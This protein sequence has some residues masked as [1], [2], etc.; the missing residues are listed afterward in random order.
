M[1]AM[2]TLQRKENEFKACTQATV[3]FDYTDSTGKVYY[4]ENLRINDIPRKQIN[5]WKAFT[6]HFV[7]PALKDT[8]SQ[9]N[10]YINNPKGALFEIK[11]IDLKL[12]NFSNKQ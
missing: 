4:N 2:V 1:K 12:F 5:A 11:N 3:C 8:N 9:L 7:M 10:F 6:Y